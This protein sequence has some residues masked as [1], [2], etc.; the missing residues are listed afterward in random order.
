VLLSRSHLDPAT[1]AYV[2]RLPEPERMAF[3]SALK[4]ALIAEG[5]ADLYPRL[6]TTSIWDVAAG[7]ALLEAAGGAMV[8]PNGRPLRYDQ[9]DFRIEAFIA[10]GD[11]AAGLP[12]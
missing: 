10:F 6:S 11:R 1:D 7:H 2:E 12:R 8:A 4:F 5:A 3:G 9:S